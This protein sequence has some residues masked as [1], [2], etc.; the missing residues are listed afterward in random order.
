MSSHVPEIEYAPRFE[1]HGFV[2]GHHQEELHVLL[3]VGHK[4]FTAAFRPEIDS[5][6]QNY[7][8]RTNSDFGVHFRPNP[9]RQFADVPKFPR[10]FG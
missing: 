4:S 8:F 2:N 10:F 5:Q 1:Q 6:D 7:P 9:M 3:P